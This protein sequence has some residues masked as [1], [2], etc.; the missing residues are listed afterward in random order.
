MAVYSTVPAQAEQIGI[1]TLE[2]MHEQELKMSEQKLGCLSSLKLT[3]RP[4]RMVAGIRSFRPQD[5]WVEAPTIGDRRV[6]GWM[7]ENMREQ[8]VENMR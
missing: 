7:Q 3:V 5:R 2:K 8:Y 4:P 1:S 6:R